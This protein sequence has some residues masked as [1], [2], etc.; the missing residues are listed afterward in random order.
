MLMYNNI[1]EELQKAQEGMLYHQKLVSM[2]EDLKI[3]RSSLMEK[4]ENL[5]SRRRKKIWT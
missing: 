5:K 4:V 3:Q 2:L 1:N